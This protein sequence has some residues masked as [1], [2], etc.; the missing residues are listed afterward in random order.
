MSIVSTQANRYLLVVGLFKLS[1]QKY[2]RCS[3]GGVNTIM[4]A[5]C[6]M[7]LSCVAQIMIQCLVH[8]VV[9][10]MFVIVIVVAQVVIMI[11][12]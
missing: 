9:I 2:P 1:V 10:V 7:M 11:M 12:L 6:L 5:L 4:S 8:T 3:W